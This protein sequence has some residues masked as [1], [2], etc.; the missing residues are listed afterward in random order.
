MDLRLAKELRHTL[1]RCGR[2]NEALLAVAKAAQ[3]YIDLIPRESWEH[4]ELRY[5]LEVARR[6]WEGDE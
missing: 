1:A 2:R 6:V 4:E 3:R 5:R